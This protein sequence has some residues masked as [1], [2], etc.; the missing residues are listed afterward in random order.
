MNGARSD[1]AL[2]NES[3]LK[4]AVAE[5]RLLQGPKLIL[6]GIP[7]PEILLADAG[8]TSNDYTLTPFDFSGVT[9]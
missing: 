1:K 9:F 6:G 5:G 8:F 2:F 4:A 7:F 3:Y